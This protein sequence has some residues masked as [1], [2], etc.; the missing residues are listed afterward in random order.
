MGGKQ[1]YGYVFAEV[2]T[3]TSCGLSQ[4]FLIAATHLHWRLFKWW[5]PKLMWHHHHHK[6]VICG[7]TKLTSILCGN[8]VVINL[9]LSFLPLHPFAKE[10]MQI[11]WPIKTLASLV[12]YNPHVPSTSSCRYIELDVRPEM[13]KSFYRHFLLHCD[14]LRATLAFKFELCLLARTLN[15]HKPRCKW[16]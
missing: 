8:S 10:Y 3:I 1:H 2:I 11:Y 9:I 5:W 16:P 15:S 14:G 13:N 7:F 6:H 12:R 4:H